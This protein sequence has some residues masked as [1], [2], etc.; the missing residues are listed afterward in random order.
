VTEYPDWLRDIERET[1]R[2]ALE[3]GKVAPI[4]NPHDFT[5]HVHTVIWA[6]IL[7]RQRQG[8]AVEYVSVRA[9]LDR[10]GQL[11]AVGPI[12]L[13]ELAR[14]SVRP[15]DQALSSAAE[16]I[17]NWGRGRRARA[18]LAKYRTAEHIDPDEIIAAL[19]QAIDAPSDS[20]PQFETLR[21]RLA[22]PA[23]PVSYRIEGWQPRQSRVMWSAPS[24]TGKTSGVANVIRCLVDGDH[25]LGRYAVEPVDRVVLVDVEMGS[26]QLDAWLRAQRIQN[27]DR[28]VP[29]ALRGQLSAFDILK[30]TVRARW[31]EQLRGVGYLIV[32]CVRPLL[33]AFGLDEHRD[34]GQLLVAID[35]LL[36][37]AEI[38]EALVIHHTG[39]GG[40][41]ARG[42][43]RFRDW[44]DVEW[45]MMRRDEDPSSPRFISAY[46]RDV[47]VAEAQIVYDAA[48][49]RLTVE[50]GSRRDAAAKD[51]LGAILDVLDG[52]RAAMSG[53]GIK[54]AMD[55]PR[56]AVDAALRFGVRSGALSVQEGP[57]RARLYRRSGSV[58]GVSGECP[59]DTASECPAAYIKP[60][61]RTLT[62]PF[63]AVPAVRTL[64]E[65][66]GAYERI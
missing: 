18:V 48:T 16:E 15:S 30:P 62:P 39:H 50:D 6:S 31:A 40:E 21:D 36:R 29:I 52:S 20:L 3:W 44:P 35:A 23:V 14:D 24:K 25:W 8:Q 64:D 47:D 33:D 26:N 53:R 34:A 57:R 2:W 51:A 49:R 59:P 38:P 9:D 13:N 10:K 11:E 58:S 54:D 1:I 55:L 28:V 12:Y 42:D 19:R 37:E 60:D 41:R 46:G 22:R 56:D 32:D 4:E 66:D 65:T 17:R 61:T 43:S 7:S 63:D 27:D 5:R 45:R